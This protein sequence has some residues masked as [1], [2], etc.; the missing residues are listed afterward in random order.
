MRTSMP[1]IGSPTW[2]GTRRSSV[3]DRTMPSSVIPYRSSRTWPLISRQRSSVDTG[4]A[5]EP[6][7]ISRSPAAPADHA[8]R[9]SSSACSHAAA[10]RA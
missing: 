8:R 9:V 1:G 7:T 10:S 6:H 3:F 4:S 2:P 5:A